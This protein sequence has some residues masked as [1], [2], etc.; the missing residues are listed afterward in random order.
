[1]TGGGGKKSEALVFR[2]DTPGV[3]EWPIVFP[4]QPGRK[5]ERRIRRVQFELF[6]PPQ[7]FDMFRIHICLSSPPRSQGGREL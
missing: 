4:G 1:M 3:I 2:N 7:E 6:Q 5:R